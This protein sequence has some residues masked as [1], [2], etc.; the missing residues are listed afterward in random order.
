MRRYAGRPEPAAAVM[1]PPLAH[2]EA[3]EALD[4]DPLAGLGVHAVDQLSNLRLAR[5]VL[6]EGLLEQALIGEEL[7]E[8]ALDDLVEHLR[9]LLL[10]RQLP[11]VDLA[12]LL[13][14]LARDVF[15]RDVGRIRRRD[16]HPEV[17]H[18]IL[19]R[20]GTRDEVG[21]AVDLDQHAELGPV[22]DVRTDGPLAGFS[23]R[24]LAGLGQALLS[25]ELDG[26]LQI[27]LR[28]L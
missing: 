2:L 16:L 9:R 21:L 12:L 22:V 18:E 3:G 27:A 6:D 8:L 7:L 23:V 17:L 19:E 11:P 1:L 28:D 10:V 20:V 26:R 4:D 24:T 15:P 13:D 25:K 5:G 14:H